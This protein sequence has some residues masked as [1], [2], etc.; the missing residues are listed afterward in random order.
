MK[1]IIIDTGPLIAFLNANDKHHLWAKENFNALKPPFFCCEAVLAETCFLLNKIKAGS[2]S[3][4][5]M[6][7]R[8]LIISSFVLK[9]EITVI[10]KLMIRYKDVPISLADACLVRM[11]EQ[12]ADSTIFTLDQD[13]LIYRRHGREVISTLM[14]S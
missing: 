3:I 6:L 13:F 9:D 2:L 11:S 1:K 8:N 5:E 4:F 10:K 12:H 14:P 7:Q